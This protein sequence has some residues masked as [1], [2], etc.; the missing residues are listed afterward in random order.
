MT[1]NELLTAYADGH[2]Y[3][4]YADLSGANLS[5]ANLSGANL[6]GADLSRANLSGANLYGAD[7]SRANL[8]RANLDGANMDGAKLPHFQI[9]PEMGA[10]VA[11]KKLH[12]DLIAEIE[13]PADAPRTS[14]LVG[15]KCRAAWV[16]VRAIFDA[17]GQ[18]VD[19][20]YGLHDRTVYEVGQTVI[21][22]D[23]DDDI[24]VEC[25]HGIHFFVTLQEAKDYNG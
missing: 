7:L 12:D 18:P 9:V 24:R 10:F 15:R 1:A 8:F 4:A 13:I 21:A 5:G 11:F 3:F 6:Y 14:S 19:I 17:N 25:T 22:D 16:T 2:R 23:W 20:G